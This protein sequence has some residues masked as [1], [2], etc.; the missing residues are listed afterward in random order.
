[1][2]RGLYED[3]HIVTII[4][5]MVPAWVVYEDDHRERIH[6]FALTEDRHGGRHIRPVEVH[7]QAPRF[8]DHDFI[9]L[10]DIDVNEPDPAPTMP[11]PG[12]SP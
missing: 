9:E 2:R 6:L 3:E 8:P 11:S 1:M 12:K 10:D 5:A 7:G 4:P